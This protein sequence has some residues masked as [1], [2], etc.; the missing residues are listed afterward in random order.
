MSKPRDPSPLVGW[1][2]TVAVVVVMNAV[3]LTSPSVVVGAIASTIA[4]GAIATLVAL[5]SL[6]MGAGE[7]WSYAAVV[8]CVAGCLYAMLKAYDAW[9]LLGIASF[10]LAL[11]VVAIHLSVANRRRWAERKAKRDN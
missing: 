3:I 10:P 8:G 7:G 9:G 2:V 11:I 5:V 4:V 1:P 6:R